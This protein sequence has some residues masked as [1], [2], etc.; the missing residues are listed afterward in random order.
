MNGDGGTGIAR[1]AGASTRK[2]PLPRRLLGNKSASQCRGHSAGLSGQQLNEMLA[3][4]FRDERAIAAARRFISSNTNATVGRSD[5]VEFLRHHRDQLAAADIEY[6]AT[7]T[8]KR[9]LSSRAMQFA[10]NAT[11]PSHPNDG[12]V[13]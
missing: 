2:A 3:T 5:V 9:W 10:R 11:A 4:H 12:G 8:I 1:P 6:C 7:E 13:P